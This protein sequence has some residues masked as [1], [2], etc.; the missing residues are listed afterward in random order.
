MTFVLLGLLQ[1][2]RFLV[3]KKAVSASLCVLSTVNT[4]SDASLYVLSTVN[5]R[6]DA[7]L[8][9]L[10]TV[11]TRSDASLCVLSN[12]NTRSDASNSLSLLLAPAPCSPTS[13]DAL[14]RR[15]AFIPHVIS[16]FRREVDESCA[17]LCSYATSSDN[18]LP[19]F[20]DSCP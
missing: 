12:V 20:L 17:L 16:G 2:F 5:T 3:L 19:T 8:Y 6:S 18:S 15:T 1:A 4:R 14:A 11:N 13:T 9:V 7:S 10:S